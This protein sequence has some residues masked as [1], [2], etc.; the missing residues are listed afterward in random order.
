[1]S[2]MDLEYIGSDTLDVTVIEKIEKEE[3]INCSKEDSKDKDICMVPNF[4]K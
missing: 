1:M 3:V 4:I 2:G